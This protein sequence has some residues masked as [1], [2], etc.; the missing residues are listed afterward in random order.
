MAARLSRRIS[1]H[2]KRHIF[3]TMTLAID[4]DSLLVKSLQGHSSISTTMHHAKPT[5]DMIKDSASPMG[6]ALPEPSTLTPR[7]SN[8]SHREHDVQVL[9]AGSC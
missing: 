9:H 1:L 2:D 3:A 4:V 5:A 6:D 7:H 8:N